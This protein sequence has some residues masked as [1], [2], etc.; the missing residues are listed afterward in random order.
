MSSK[1]ELKAESERKLFVLFAH[2][3]VWPTGAELI[4]SRPEP[5]PDILYESPG[6][7]IAFELVENCS[8]NLAHNN[9]HLLD[10]TGKIILNVSDPT[11]ETIRRKISKRYASNYPIELLCYSSGRL[12]TPNDLVTIRIRNEFETARQNPFR[13]VWYFGKRNEVNMVWQSST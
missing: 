6:G 9:A 12:A 1:A 2:A 7:K 10:G 3:L 13:R 11:I 8:N 5:E 4:Q